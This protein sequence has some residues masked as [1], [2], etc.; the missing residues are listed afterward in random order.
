MLIPDLDAGCSLAASITADQLRAWKAE[1][2]GAV[3]VSYVNTTA[4]VKAETDYC[5]TSGNAK[6]VIEA[7]PADREILFL[8]GH[9]PRHLARARDRPQAED[10]AGRVPRARRHPPGRH[11]A[12]AGRRAGRRAA[13][14]P[15]VRLREPVHGFRQRAHAHPLHRGDGQL[16]QGVAEEALPRRDR[17]R[18]PPPAEQG[19]ARASASRPSP[20][21]RSAST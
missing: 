12:L 20:S 15:R 11:R 10:L 1:H 17:D 13:R 2:P 3:V 18:D 6:A 5:C 14:P 19:G 16:R 8:P 9:V 7:I 4:E 21:G